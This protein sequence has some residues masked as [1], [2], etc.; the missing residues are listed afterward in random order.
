M[1][2]MEN[3]KTINEMASIK[4]FEKLVGDKCYCRFFA[5]MSQIEK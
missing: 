1:G 3:M 4:E 5:N 2:F